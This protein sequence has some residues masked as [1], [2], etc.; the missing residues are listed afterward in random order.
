MLVMTSHSTFL[1]VI[2]KSSTSLHHYNQNE[3]ALLCVFILVLSLVNGIG[4]DQNGRSHSSI[5]LVSVTTAATL[6]NHLS[7]SESKRIYLQKLPKIIFLQD[8]Q[9]Y[10]IYTATHGRRLRIYIPP[11]SDGVKNQLK[12]KNV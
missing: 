10:N 6:L 12:V 9:I 8:L 2:K 5:P 11:C 3:D 7:T 4:V 1:K